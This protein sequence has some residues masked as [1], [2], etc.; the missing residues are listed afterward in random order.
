MAITIAANGLSIVHKGSGAEA[1][2]TLPDVCLTK[3][4]KPVVPIPYGNNAKSSDL[5]GGTTT[6]TADGGNSIALKDSTFSKSTGDAGGDKKGVSSGTIE[7]EAKFIS[8]SPNVLIEGKG[9]ARMTDQMTMN[10][11]NTMCLGGVQSESV[12]VDETVEELQEIEI[13]VRY[14]N[15]KRLANA[16]FELVDESGAYV[17]SG[18]LDSAG[19]SAVKE[20]EPTREAQL[21]VR[22][23]FDEYVL[24]PIRRE[25]PHFRD[26]PLYDDVPDYE[27]FDI[28]IKGQQGFWQHTRVDSGLL[29]GC[30][31]HSLIE[32]KYFHDI[33]EAEV[34]THFPYLHPDSEYNFDKIC[35][36][37]LGSL[38]EPLPHTTEILL[39]YVMPAALEEGQILSVIL[40]LAPHETINRLLSYLRHLGLGNPVA[41]LKG[42]DWNNASRTMIQDVM[43][44]LFKKLTRRLVFLRDQAASLKYSYLSEEVF[45]KH[46]D[47]MVDYVEVLRSLIFDVFKKM[48]VKVKQLLAQLEDNNIIRDQEY[49]FSTLGNTITAVVDTTS[50]L[51]TVE[52]YLKEFPGL[53][54]HVIPIYPVR[55]AYADLFD[56]EREPSLPPTLPEMQAA[57]GFKETGGYILRIL[58]EGWIYIKEE[59]DEGKRPFQIFKYVQVE[60]PTGVLEKFERYLFLN[61]ENAQDGLKLD[62]SSGQTFYPFAFVTPN[63]ESISIAYCEHEWAASIIDKMNEDE[64]F[65]EKAM[66]RID[67]TSE[68]T[69]YSVGVTQENLE[70][71]VEDYR[72]GDHRWLTAFEDGQPEKHGWD[73]STSTLSYHLRADE[74]IEEMRKS[75]CQTKPGTIIAL[76]DPVGRQ[77]DITHALTLTIT[78]SHAYAYLNDYPAKMGI[79]VDGIVESNDEGLKKIAEENLDLKTYD[80]F[81]NVFYKEVNNYKARREYLIKHMD[82]FINGLGSGKGDVSLG[83]LHGYGKY[84][85]ERYPD[86]DYLSMPEFTKLLNFY[87][88]IMGNITACEEGMQAKMMWINEAFKGEE[89]VGV[90][91]LFWEA[92]AD[93]CKKLF[94]HPQDASPWDASYTT[95]SNAFF[96]YFANLFIKIQVNYT[97]KKENKAWQKKLA[98][99]KGVELFYR[100]YLPYVFENMLGIRFTGSTIDVPIS[101]IEAKV[102]NPG[103]N[104]ASRGINAGIEK[105]AKGLLKL[106]EIRAQMKVD[107]MMIKLMEIKPVQPVHD[108]EKPKYAPEKN[109]GKYPES[110]RLTL[111]DMVTAPLAR[112]FGVYMAKWSFSLNLSTIQSVL[113]QT[114]FETLEEPALYRVTELISA[115]TAITADTIAIAHFGSYSVN[116]FARGAQAV[117]NGTE[118]VLARMLPSISVQ[119]AQRLG[120]TSLV[121]YSSRLESSLSNLVIT[122]PLLF[123][124]NIAMA[125]LELR[126]GF[127]AFRAGRNG[128]LTARIVQAGLLVFLAATVWMA[129]AIGLACFFIGFAGLYI[130]GKNI[131]RLDK[132]PFENFLFN[133]FWGK[134]ERYPFWQDFISSEDQLKKIINP[135]ERLKLLPVLKKTKN[136][137]LKRAMEIETQEF[138]NYFYRPYVKVVAEDFY[139]EQTGRRMYIKEYAFSLAAFKLGISQL[140]G[141]IMTVPNKEKLSI[142]NMMRNSM[143]SELIRINPEIPEPE[144]DEVLTNELARQL[145]Q[146]IEKHIT[147]L[148]LAKKESMEQ[149]KESN[150]SRFELKVRLKAEHGFFLKWCYQPSPDITVP[151]RFLTEFFEIKSH[152]TIGMNDNK[153]E[154]LENP[155]EVFL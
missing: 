46:I 83:T 125:G 103:K 61:E 20:L 115:L 49:S 139:D 71:L 147:A 39:A 114:D 42:F 78:D 136:E 51:D 64:T 36:V 6:V 117:M 34:K 110:K 50:T 16:P 121:A 73:L 150:I 112:G 47:V 106:T 17:D 146:E 155:L 18:M 19:K 98:K 99:A 104:F 48:S 30:M 101:E 74:L 3:V 8:A 62:T 79:F 41:Y 44:P 133:S 67:L 66:Q 56:E 33:L 57:S 96:Y 94:T 59:G 149:S 26:D 15:G 60:T 124:A 9:V 135:E 38:D 43:Q 21:I 55:F 85:I 92:L 4:G 86:D 84:F 75:T 123:A 109:A 25:N 127:I 10:K 93:L 154:I 32:D 108:K 120:V 52:P 13:I 63:T 88:G 5:A 68:S 53:I 130:N 119:A 89:S 82:Y 70:S 142:K 126:N 81:K 148:N 24:N 134:S 72:L 91:A 152:G 128:L 35:Q 138:H 23:S 151:K 113:A 100:E 95:L 118:A 116:I 145:E 1:N 97:Y 80:D 141:E 131:D 122:K 105:V 45:Q 40:R 102:V 153:Y 29:W 7:A 22:E 14:P 27:F 2:A 87:L 111:L 69:D 76:F 140:Q 132:S 144:V 143:P 129:P 12:S 65:R 54:E 77:R 31:G 58:R 11:G 28:A 90:V 107:P 137:Y 37:I